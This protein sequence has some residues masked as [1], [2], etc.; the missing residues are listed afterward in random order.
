[1]AV[2]R[3]LAS[4]IR[5]LATSN[6]TQATGFGPSKLLLVAVSWHVSVIWRDG[7][8]C[9][10]AIRLDV[11]RS[12]TKCR[13]RHT[14]KHNNSQ[15][16]QRYQWQQE[17]HSQQQWQKQ[18][19]VLSAHATG[20][21]CRDIKINWHFLLLPPTLHFFFYFC[22]FILFFFLCKIE[23]TKGKISQKLEEEKERE[24]RKQKIR[25]KRHAEIMSDE[26]AAS[27]PQ[28]SERKSNQQRLD[29]QIPYKKNKL[30]NSE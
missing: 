28:N 19:L 30:D 9:G 13:R 24:N 22:F 1:M 6:R 10:W 26:A 20:K 2:I 12:Q 3:H 29:A 23:H 21:P 15:F 27:G 4:G 8:C 18:E 7:R 5:Q 11:L 14:F 16:R 17:H 25:L